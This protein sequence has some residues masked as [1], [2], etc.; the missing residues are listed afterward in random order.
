MT[1]DKDLMTQCQNCE[2]VWLASKLRA[3]DPA[4]LPERVAPGEPMP[5]GECPEC[6]AVCH[7]VE[8]IT[9]KELGNQHGYVCPKCGSGEQINI[10]AR[11]WVLLVPN[12]TE[13]AEGD[14]DSG[15][16]WD[17]DNEAHCGACDWSGTVAQLITGKKR[18]DVLRERLQALTSGEPI[19]QQ[20]REHIAGLRRLIGPYGWANEALEHLDHF[21][22]TCEKVAK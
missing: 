9:S 2:K 21:A 3:I 5:D 15:E 14:M 13:D 16:E 20:V 11:H 7:R 12:G 17:N 1:L 6:G 4:T 19:R 22:D 8:S 10:A 18:G